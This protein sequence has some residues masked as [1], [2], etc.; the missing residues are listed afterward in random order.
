LD[1]V[2][3]LLSVLQHDQPAKTSANFLDDYL[4]Y[5]ALQQ[6]LGQAAAGDILE[7]FLVRPGEK[8]D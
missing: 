3:P 4:R 8:V 5:R 1:I 6:G 2:K 7:P